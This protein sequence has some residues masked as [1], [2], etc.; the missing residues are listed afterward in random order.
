MKNFLSSFVAIVALILFLPII[1]IM[2]I[3]YL[4]FVPFDIIRYH[5]MPYYKD[6]KI[7]YRFFI[8]S[9]DIVKMYN[10]IVQR[11]LQIEYVRH[12]DYEY[13]IKDGVALLCGWSHDAFDEADG[14][15][16]WYLYDEDGDGESRE[17]VE[18]ALN[19]DKVLLKPEH[20]SLHAK[21]LMFYEGIPDSEIFEKAMQCPSFYCVSS[22]D[23]I[24]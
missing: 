13:F 24:D 17:S 1:C 4:L 15:W 6:L 20:Q 10:Y 5:R 14:E 3:C 23:E 19:T 12:N 9:S 7:K 22:M 16:Y 8:T 21:Y 11:N 18:D 2:C